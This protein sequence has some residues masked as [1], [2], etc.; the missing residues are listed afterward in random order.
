MTCAWDPAVSTAGV[1]GFF[2][3]VSCTCYDR[4]SVAEKYS[5]ERAA[6]VATCCYLQ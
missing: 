1:L 4:P 6:N 5:T 3:F 2:T